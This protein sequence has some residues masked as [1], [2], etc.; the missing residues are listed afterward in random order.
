VLFRSVSLN[1]KLGK[2]EQ[3]NTGTAMRGDGVKK[4]AGVPRNVSHDGVKLAQSD[5]HGTEP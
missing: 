3:V 4:F 1:E 5:F 2:N